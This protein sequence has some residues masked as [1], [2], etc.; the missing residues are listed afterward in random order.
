MLEITTELENATEIKTHATENEQHAV[1]NEEPESLSSGHTNSDYHDSGTTGRLFL[2]YFK[3][4][5]VTVIML[6]YVDDIVLTEN[7]E[8]FI[9]T[10]ITQ[11]SLEFVL[12]DL[13]KLHYFLGLEVQYFPGGI[14]PSQGKY[15]KYL[16]NRAKLIESS[17]FN[18]PMALKS[19]PTPE[20][21]KVVNAEEYR[22]LVG[23]LQYLTYTRSDIVQAVNKVCQKLNKPTEGDMKAVKRIFFYLRGTIYYGIKFLAQSPLK[24]Y[25]FCDADWEGC[26][27]TRRSTA[28]YCIYLGANCIS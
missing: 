16:L 2:I 19:Q 20:D 3:K 13:G 10:L 6:I 12:K 17:H 23:A 21:S 26:P 8:E 5:V 24:L 4:K 25:G 22:S 14:T 1:G 7:N 28:G 9:Q 27:N 11:L 15:T 18:T